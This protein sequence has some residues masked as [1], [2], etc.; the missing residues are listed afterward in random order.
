MDISTGDIL[1]IVGVTIP[2]IIAIV[3]YCIYVDRRF[4]KLEDEL[5][6]FK[7]IKEIL[8]KKGQEHVVSVFNKEREP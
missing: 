2:F 6:I 8:M 7:P 5:A 3:G 1:A 4:K